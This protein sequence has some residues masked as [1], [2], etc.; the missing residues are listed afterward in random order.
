MRLQEL[1]GGAERFERPWCSL[2][3]RFW[4]QWR[5]LVE[6]M[7]TVDETVRSSRPNIRQQQQE[8]PV[9]GLWNLAYPAARVLDVCIGL[10]MRA[11]GR[12]ARW[13]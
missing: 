4:W 1:S 5:R 13:M 3:S 9:K 8:V 10:A 11:A 2:L 6:K 7:N 12:R